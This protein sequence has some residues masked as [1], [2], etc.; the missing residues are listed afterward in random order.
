MDEENTKVFDLND[1]REVILL[2]ENS[3]LKWKNVPWQV[4]S[5]YLDTLSYT[6]TIYKYIMHYEMILSAT[7]SCAFQHFYPANTKK[8][9]NFSKIIIKKIL[10]PEEWGM[11]PLKEMNYIHPEQKVSKLSAS[12]SKIDK[13]KEIPTKEGSY[14]MVEVQNLLVERI[15]LISFPTMINDL[16]Q[17]INNIKEDIQ[18]LKEKNVIIEL[19]AANSS[20]TTSG[21]NTYHPMY[22]EFMDFI[23][24]KKASNNNPPAYF[25]VLMDEENMEVFDLNDKREVI[26]LLEN[27]HLKWKNDPWQVEESSSTATAAKGKNKR[28]VKKDLMK[29]L[30]IDIKDDISMASASHTNDDDDNT[31]IAREGQDVDSNEEVDLNALFLKILLFFFIKVIEKPFSNRFPFRFL[32]FFRNLFLVG[33]L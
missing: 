25:A 11:S 24:S 5:R 32:K 8:V 20:T 30:D 2:L 33:D 19:V 17:E 12:T 9:Y 6:T 7:G 27:S 10:A 16:K 28:I 3:D 26:L 18:Q 22:R 14:T 23:K 1:K 13:I 4:M 31:C 21:I 29:N 15:K